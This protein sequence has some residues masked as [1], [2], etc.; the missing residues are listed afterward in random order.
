VTNPIDW[1]E[2]RSPEEAAA[3]TEEPEEAARV[4]AQDDAATRARQQEA[5]AGLRAADRALADGEVRLRE[6]RADLQQREQ[7]LERTSGLTREV[8]QNAAELREQTAQI[9][10]ETRRTR[11]AAPE[12]PPTGAPTEGDS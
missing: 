2:T 6:T 11:R 9:V 8:A 7:E 4:R 12:D 1:R 3:Q 5:E 10:E